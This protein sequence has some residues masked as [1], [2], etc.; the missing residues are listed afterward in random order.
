[1]TGSAGLSLT[2][3]TSHSQV[4]QQ[5]L[6][7]ILASWL[8]GRSN[9]VLCFSGSSSHSSEDARRGGV[10]MGWKWLGV[11]GVEMAGCV[12]GGNGAGMDALTET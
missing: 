4:Q 5:L 8:T 3:P 1:M 2:P 9:S 12:W 11:Y 7:L 10:C 6:A